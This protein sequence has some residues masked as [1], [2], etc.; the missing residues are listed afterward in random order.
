MRRLK[1]AGVAFVVLLAVV[2]TAVFVV[3]EVRVDD[4]MDN[5]GRWFEGR[6]DL[7]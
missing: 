6:C 3:H 1:I 5:G 4:C 2:V 7:P